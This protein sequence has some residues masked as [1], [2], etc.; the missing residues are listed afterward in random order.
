MPV[1][2]EHRVPLRFVTPAFLGGATGASELRTPPFKSLLRRWWRV[3]EVRG[4]TPDLAGL[5]EKEGV[6]FGHAWLNDEQNKPWASRSQVRLAV[7]AWT[8]GTQTEWPWTDPKVTHPEV[9]RGGRVGAHLYLGYGPLTHKKGAGTG[10][11]SPPAMAPDS[12]FDLSLR[13]GSHVASAIRLQD[14]AALWAWFGTIGSRSRN[15]WGSLE[16]DNGHQTASWDIRSLLPFSREFTSCFD[17]EWPHAIG[18]DDKGLLIWRTKADYGSWQDALKVLAE[19]KIA[20]RTPRSLG[21]IGSPI[22]GERH[23]L[24]YPITHHDVPAWDQGGDES[25]RLANQLCLKVLKLTDGGRVRYRGLAVHLPHR[26]PDP[27]LDKLDRSAR[28]EVRRTE[29]DVWR[30]VHATLDARMT[31]WV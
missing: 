29:Q 13:F 3:A 21:G 15:G 16:V 14:V 23:V 1:Y 11:K 8:R 26:L 10:L 2:E 31:R 25:F 7:T 9:D 18:R 30:K 20:F 22:F 5:R 12:A 27:M 4:G 28:S 24:S 6:L 19:I 17:S